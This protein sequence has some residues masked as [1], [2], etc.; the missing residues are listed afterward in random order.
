MELALKAQVVMGVVLGQEGQ[1]AG[2]FSEEADFPR[3]LILW[4]PDPLPSLLERESPLVL[5]GPLLVLSEPPGP[6]YCHL[7]TFGPTRVY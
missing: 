5:R 3:L 4:F 1:G 7:S 6:Q 2:G